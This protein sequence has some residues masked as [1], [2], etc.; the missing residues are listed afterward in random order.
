M[1]RKKDRDALKRAIEMARTL[2]EPI[3]AE[4]VDRMSKS[5]TL[6]EAGRYASYHLQMKSLRLRP[7]MC[8]PCDSDDKVDP[9]GLSGGKPEEVALRRRMIAAGL[10]VYEPD[11]L[12]ALE[13]AEA[14]AEANPL[15]AA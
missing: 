7:W 10:S 2:L 8:P 3:I 13:H 15:P 4:A 6:E 11:P 14:E 1:T 5:G 9:T 12:G